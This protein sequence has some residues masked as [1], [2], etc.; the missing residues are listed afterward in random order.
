MQY[1]TRKILSQLVAAD[2]ELSAKGRAV[3]STHELDRKSVSRPSQT[4][5]TKCVTLAV[6]TEC[7]VELSMIG[8]PLDSDTKRFE[9]Y[10]A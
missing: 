4:I 2:D 8:W 9:M 1:G 5:P 10:K 7:S 3:G 6:T